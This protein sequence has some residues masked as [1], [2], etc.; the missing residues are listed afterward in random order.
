MR[1]RDGD[2]R[3]ALMVIAVGPDGKVRASLGTTAIEMHPREVRRLRQLYLEAM[4]AAFEEGAT[5]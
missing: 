3:D 5:W 2:G 4:A 1:V